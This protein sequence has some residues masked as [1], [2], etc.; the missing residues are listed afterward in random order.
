MSFMIQTSVGGIT[1]QIPPDHAMP[2]STGSPVMDAAPVVRWHEPT[3]RSG[4]GV[5]VGASQEMFTTIG[6]SVINS[7]GLV[8]WYSTLGMYSNIWSVTV[9]VKLLNPTSG[10]WEWFS[11]TAW[12]PTFTSGQAG[13]KV[14][15][16]RIHI[17]NLAPVESPEV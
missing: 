10:A 13:N 7:S 1:P 6:R 3:A 17:S 2:S 4:T 5:P 16:F 12:R 11:G 14:R 15:D 9:K 8:W